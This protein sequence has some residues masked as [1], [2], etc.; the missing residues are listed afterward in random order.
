LVFWVSPMPI[1]TLVFLT[2]AL[3]LAG[4]YFA[5]GTALSRLARMLGKSLTSGSNANL[6]LAL[7]NLHRAGAPTGPVVMALGL[8][9]TLLVALD[10]IS[11]AAT[12]HIQQS[13][14]HS[15]PDLVAFSLK[16]ETA[17]R[18]EDELTSSGLVERQRIMPFLHARVQAIGGIPVRDLAIPR[19]LHWVIR[20]DR[21]VSFASTLPNDAQWADA[22]SDQPG[23]SV[24][25]GVA[26]DL[27][28]ERGD[29][30]TLNTGGQIRTGPILGFRKIDWTALDLDFP[31]IANPATFR[32]IPYSLA[33]S[34]K[35]APGKQADL[36]AFIKTRFP[37][38]PL[39][40]VPD[41]LQS[42][43]MALE[44]I[45]TG[46][47]SAAL[48]CGLAA[49]MVLAGSI[50]QGLEQRTVDAAIFKILGARKRQLTGQLMMEFIALGSLVAL[51]ALPLGLAVAWAVARAAGLGGLDVS[52]TGSLALAIT[53][54]LVTLAVG[55]L[56]T[57]N[58]YSVSPAQVLRR[59]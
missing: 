36:E 30:I 53:A 23:F 34:L 19:S 4:L 48:L 49:L 29:T 13:L 56:V 47:N 50:L 14:P 37:D 28:L 42:L 41:V 15:A 6:R 27:G 40:K 31:I 8:T 25:A 44:I 1:L 16:P 52:W 58:I 17:S 55:L 51:V 54:I 57:L 11:L 20:G 5:L 10:G 59:R 9:L 3:V 7:S 24:D 33:A 39:I 32:D 21:G 12:R 26:T 35:A 45:L 2:G 46:L 22:G 43:A 38:V 18:L